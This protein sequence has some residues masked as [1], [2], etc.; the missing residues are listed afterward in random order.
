MQRTPA[1]AIGFEDM[2][3]KESME[4]ETV[5]ISEGS[6]FAQ[7]DDLPPQSAVANFQ[8]A[9]ELIDEDPPAKL[10]IRSFIIMGGICLGGD[11]SEKALGSHSIDGAVLLEGGALSF[12]EG[13][14]ILNRTGSSGNICR[15][16]HF[17][18]PSEVDVAA[19]QGVWDVINDLAE[20]QFPAYLH[21]LTIEGRIWKAGHNGGILKLRNGYKLVTLDD[22]YE[23]S[24]ESSCAILRLRPIIAP[25]CCFAVPFSRN[26]DTQL[27]YMR[28][29]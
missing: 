22:Q 11:G 14:R 4:N 3:N 5:T 13:G 8:G 1:S 23:L 19:L 28:R 6:A 18:L 27:R 2:E 26:D 17:D 12:E 24:L 29:A 25:L 20:L 15:F 7:A 10:C 21:V 16:R 9:W